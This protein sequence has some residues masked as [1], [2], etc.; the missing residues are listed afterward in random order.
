MGYNPDKQTT[1]H[2][3]RVLITKIKY[4]QAELKY[5]NTTERTCPSCAVC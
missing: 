4:T 3:N 5:L 2:I 1:T